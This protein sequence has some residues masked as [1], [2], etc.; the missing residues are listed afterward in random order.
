VTGKKLPDIVAGV[1]AAQLA[2][3]DYQFVFGQLAGPHVADGT[4]LPE[5]PLSFRHA[6][7]HPIESSG[8]SWVPKCMVTAQKGADVPTALAT[9]QDAIRKSKSIPHQV[10][11]MRMAAPATVFE[12]PVQLCRRLGMADGRLH[13]KGGK[14][15]A[16]G[17]S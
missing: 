1:T 7:Q 2:V 13:D 5:P 4:L 12:K 17:R 8:L 14:E 15:R 11:G 10:A 3:P 9:P 16:D 6:D